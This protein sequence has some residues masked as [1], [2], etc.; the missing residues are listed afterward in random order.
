MLEF[1]FDTFINTIISYFI[2]A[3]FVISGISAKVFSGLSSLLAEDN[4]N[5]KNWRFMPTPVFAYFY[6]LVTV[7]SIFVPMD[8]SVF[9]ITV[10]NLSNIFM[11]IFAYVGFYYAVDFFA[12]R[13]RRGFATVITIVAIL[14][15]ARFSLNLLSMLG[16]YRVILEGRSKFNN[17]PKAE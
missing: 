15:L 6:L 14:L 16:M 5:I 10:L 17:P 4:T 11:A 12:K 2:I 3:G 13:M 7:A 8:S 9:S 1:A